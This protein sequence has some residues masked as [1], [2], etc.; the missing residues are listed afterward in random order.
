MQTLFKTISTSSIL[1]KA[2][3]RP[4]AHALQSLYKT[5]A[6]AFTSSLSQIC[7]ASSYRRPAHLNRSEIFTGTPVK[8]KSFHS[9]L[10]VLADSSAELVPEQELPL[11]SFVDPTRPGLFYHFLEPPTFISPR[12]PVYALSFLP[13]VPPLPDSS[14]IIGWLPASTE[15]EAEQEAGL[16]DFR[17][18]PK[19]RQLLHEAVK[20]GL[21]ADVDD[22]QRNGALQI[23]QGWM[24][25]HGMHVPND[26]N[27]P[28]LGRIG[29]P[30]DI[31]AS[32]F[33]EDGKIQADT[34]QP[35]PAYRLCT[36]DGI[37]R[38]TE[39]LSGNL[40]KILLHRLEMERKE[41]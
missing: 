6:V 5:T 33:V 1:F 24:H 39:G 21:Q 40:Q 9:C 11:G 37:T 14:T 22:I 17:E 7:F 3:R 12:L 16:N 23:Q 18:N 38:L 27:I 4:R 25:I 13:S 35:M 36:S 26:R 41:C 10:E 30:D 29:D 8:H 20:T 19:F 15:S 2:I 28:P 31:L 34:Y 32:V